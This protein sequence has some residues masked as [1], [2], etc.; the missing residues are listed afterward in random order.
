[1]RCCRRTGGTRSSCAGPAAASAYRPGPGSGCV[2]RSLRAPPGRFG[3]G[4]RAR[5]LGQQ[6]QCA[7][8]EG[9]AALVEAV[10]LNRRQQVDRGGGRAWGQQR[11]RR[12]RRV[13]G[14][15]GEAAARPARRRGGP[16]AQG[17]VAIGG[18]EFVGDAAVVFARI[19]HPLFGQRGAGAV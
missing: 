2:L 5:R 3:G 12:H 19:A 11:R 13:L 7:P 18:R 9:G 16:A 4:G 10:G 6:R 14:G 1:G 8:G 17:L 15:R